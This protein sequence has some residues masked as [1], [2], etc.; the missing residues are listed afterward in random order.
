MTLR[1]KQSLFSKLLAQLILYAYA[2]GYEITFGD[3]YAKTGHMAKSLH[4]LRLAADLNLFKDG[5]WLTDG[6]GHNVLHDYWDKLG[7][8]P[9]ITKDLNHYS[10]E[11]EGRV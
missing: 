9:R 3:V 11:H 6:S 1:E 10:L 7:G 4:Y 5:K 8:S 2:Q